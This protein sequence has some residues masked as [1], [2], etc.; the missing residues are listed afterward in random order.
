MQ[1]HVIQRP[2]RIARWFH[3]GRH[4][5]SRAVFLLEYWFI[6]R[7]KRSGAGGACHYNASAR[8]ILQIL[9]KIVNGDR[10]S[11]IKFVIKQIIDPVGR[12]TH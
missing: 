4:L 9:R 1:P 7:G 11:Q 12:A 10:T 3:A 2:M 6:S 8:P 5:F